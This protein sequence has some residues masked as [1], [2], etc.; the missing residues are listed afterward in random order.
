MLGINCK[1]KKMERIDE[2]RE[3]AN[4]L[5]DVSNLLKK[6]RY[7]DWCIALLMD[8]TH[9]TASYLVK[10]MTISECRRNRKMIQYY[11]KVIKN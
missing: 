10:P 9:R 3:E 2:V 11:E 5:L 4:Q 8:K 1:W 7:F 6:I